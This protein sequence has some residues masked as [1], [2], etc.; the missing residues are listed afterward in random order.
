M[1]KSKL[2]G[3]MPLRSRPVLGV[4]RGPI[5]GGGAAS[6]GQKVS[7]LQPRN[8][9]PHVW[10]GGDFIFEISCG[11][12]ILPYSVTRSGSRCTGSLLILLGALDG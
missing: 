7:F 10:G 4:T 11:G 1:P 5:Y 12:R 6:G 3:T 8:Y 2:S 9:P